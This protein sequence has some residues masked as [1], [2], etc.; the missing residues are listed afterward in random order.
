MYPETILPIAAHIP[1]SGTAIPDSVRSQFLHWEGE[2]WRE[3]AMVTDWYTDELFGIPGIA[4]TQTPISRIVVDL[5]FGI[6]PA[7]P[8]VGLTR[9]A[10]LSSVPHANSSSKRSVSPYKPLGVLQGGKSVYG[11]VSVRACG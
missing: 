9:L 8:I 3:I 10:A 6:R 5:E 1:H 7:R 4:V 11:P 2:L